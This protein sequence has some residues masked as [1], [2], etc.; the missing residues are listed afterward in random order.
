[1]WETDL[2]EPWAD[3][4]KIKQAAILQGS[5]SWASEVPVV[6]DQARHAISSMIQRRQTGFPIW[7]RNDKLQATS[8]FAI[9]G[10]G[11]QQNWFSHDTLRCAPGGETSESCL[12]NIG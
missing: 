12:F 9:V 10:I 6:T 3:L 5:W 8:T 2:Q 1:M 7:A 11:L 4:E